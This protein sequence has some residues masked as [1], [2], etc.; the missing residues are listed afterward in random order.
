MQARCM[1][2]RGFKGD[3]E[4]QSA[5][6]EAVRHLATSAGDPAPALELL[7]DQASALLKAGLPLDDEIGAALDHAITAFLTEDL[8]RR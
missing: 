1:N 4:L 5:L 6:Q 2:R 3:P 7:R 8:P